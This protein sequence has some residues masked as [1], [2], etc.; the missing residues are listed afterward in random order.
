MDT[1]PRLK[2]EKIDVLTLDDTRIICQTGNILT[3][4][5]PLVTDE[6]H[7]ALAYYVLEKLRHKLLSETTGGAVSTGGIQAVIDDLAAM[8]ERPF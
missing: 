4:P 5:H 8:A 2:R 1:E 6:E 7:A 3:V